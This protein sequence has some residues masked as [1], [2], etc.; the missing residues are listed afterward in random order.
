MKR[1]CVTCNRFCKVGNFVPVPGE[2]IRRDGTT[3]SRRGFSKK[4]E[5][6]RCPVT[7]AAFGHQTEGVLDQ[8][9]RIEVNIPH[10]SGSQSI[11]HPFITLHIGAPHGA[12]IGV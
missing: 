8:L 9:R 10:I 11:S 3:A 6:H 7:S 5:Q 1:H 12:V 4:I 2:A